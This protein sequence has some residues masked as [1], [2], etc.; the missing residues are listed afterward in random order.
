M[1]FIVTD[2]EEVNRK[3]AQKRFANIK[4]DKDKYIYSLLSF[5]H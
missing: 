5:L 3:D 1:L 4:Y 2:K